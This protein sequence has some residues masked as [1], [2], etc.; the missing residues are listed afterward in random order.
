MR[1]LLGKNSLTLGEW[2]FQRSGASSPV[3]PTNSIDHLPGLPLRMSSD[4]CFSSC[5]FFGLPMPL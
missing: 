4:C 3:L 5:A 1:G 2:D